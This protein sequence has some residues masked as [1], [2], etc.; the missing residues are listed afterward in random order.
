MPS[1]DVTI[2]VRVRRRWLYV[3]LLAHFTAGALIALA[4][5]CHKVVESSMK[6]AAVVEGVR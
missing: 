4:R 6:R 2:T 1:L 3:A 5:L